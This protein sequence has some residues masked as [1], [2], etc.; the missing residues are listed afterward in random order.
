MP[1][2]KV[3]NTMGHNMFTSVHSR[4]ASAYQ[5]V[6]IE[7]AVSQATPH[8]LVSL[9]FEGLLKNT[10][11]ARAA[12]ARG[13]IAGKGMQITKAVRIIDEALKPALNLA[14]GGDIAANLNGLYGYCSMRLTHAN[15]HN[16]DAALADVI[17]VIEPIADGWKQ[18]GGQ[19]AN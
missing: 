7:T 19:V 11:G 15:L 3:T 12:M 18:I 9:L 10:G 6:S 8:Q 5:R 2:T 1:I 17:R 14:E 13:D 4:A 16:D